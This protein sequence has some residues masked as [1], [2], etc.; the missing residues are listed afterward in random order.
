MNTPTIVETK[1]YQGDGM[2]KLLRVIIFALAPSFVLAQETGWIQIE[3]KQSLIQAEERAKEY[4]QELDDIAAH[5]LGSGW[6]AISMGPYP[7]PQAQAIL[8]TLKSQGA[9]PRD[10][11]VSN[12]QNYRQTV[13][14]AQSAA[15]DDT[16]SV[17]GQDTAAIDIPQPAE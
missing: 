3:A 17:D 6:Y 13:W 12:G 1:G 9:V 2:Y 16:P 14:T 10:S 15:A 8:D 4:A 7:T 5:S 11:F